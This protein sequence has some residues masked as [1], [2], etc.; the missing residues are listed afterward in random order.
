MQLAR[1]LFQK[2]ILE[3]RWMKAAIFC[4]KSH[5]DFDSGDQILIS[6]I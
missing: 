2:R 3:V 5:Q 1:F 4:H 6:G